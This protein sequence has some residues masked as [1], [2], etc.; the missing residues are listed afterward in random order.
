MVWLACD[1]SARVLA[2]SNAHVQQQHS[3]LHDCVHGWPIRHGLSPQSVATSL[4]SNGSKH[5]THCRRA[6][7]CDAAL[8]VPLPARRRF[9]ADSTLPLGGSCPVGNEAVVLAS[10]P[11]VPTCDPVGMS[12]S[13]VGGMAL[14]ARHGSARGN[15]AQRS[16]LWGDRAVSLYMGRQGPRAAIR[17]WVFAAR[18]ARWQ[19]LISSHPSGSP[20][21]AEWP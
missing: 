12:A 11:S 7:L 19:H 18:A 15:G 14:V 9:I 6:K 17:R 8:N 21:R 4:V 10:L 16:A 5:T 3:C 2:V 13:T 20:R 1:R